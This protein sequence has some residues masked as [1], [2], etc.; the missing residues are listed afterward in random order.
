MSM[1]T[2]WVTDED[3]RLRDLLV[4]D[5]EVGLAAVGLSPPVYSSIY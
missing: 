4:C 3:V 2:T 1:S 5:Q